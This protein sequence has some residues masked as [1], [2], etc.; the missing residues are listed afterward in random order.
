MPRKV[1][2][3]G[4]T[5]VAGFNAPNQAEPKNAKAG[6]TY[7]IAVFGINGPISATPGNR[8]FLRDTNLGVG[9]KT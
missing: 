3:D 4:G 7:S 2:Q 5:V 6:K 9:G 8:I 1:G